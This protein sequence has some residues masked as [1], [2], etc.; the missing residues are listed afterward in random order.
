MLKSGLIGQKTTEIASLKA[1]NEKLKNEV[2]K[3]QESSEKALQQYLKREAEWVQA[4]H[5]IRE[6]LLELRKLKGALDQWTSQSGDITQVPVPSYLR[7]LGIEQRLF[8]HLE[9]EQY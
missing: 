8:E 6:E 4:T 9:F 5:L 7:L 1:E 2:Q 3:V